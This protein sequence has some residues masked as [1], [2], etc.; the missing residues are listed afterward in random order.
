MAATDQEMPGSVA[1]AYRNT[2]TYGSPTWTE[3]TS[4]QGGEIGDQ[5]D[6]GDA[7]KRV[8]RAKLYQKTQIDMASKL[9]LVANPA[10]ADYV[11]FYGAAQSKTASLDCLLLNGKISTE[12][13][14]GIRSEFQISRQKEN[15]EMGGV[16]VNNFDLM[17]IATTNGVPSTVV[18][19]AASAPTITAA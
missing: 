3:I 8:T 12:G 4:A 9:T 16:I 7:S 2:G 17:P 1:G 15:Q 5:W 19:G 6:F 14:I 11:A 10:A 18:M 13:A